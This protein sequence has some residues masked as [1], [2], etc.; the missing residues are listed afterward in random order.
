MWVVLLVA[1][2]VVISAIALLILVTW[3]VD[4]AA[5]FLLFTALAILVSFPQDKSPPVMVTCDK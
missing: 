3:G 5:S 2:A 1:A 4:L